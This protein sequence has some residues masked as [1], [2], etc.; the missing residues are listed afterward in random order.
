MNK[1]LSPVPE[2]SKR[3][4]A[5][6]PRQTAPRINPPPGSQGALKPSPEGKRTS[7]RTR[8]V[9][10]N[11]LITVFVI[12]VMGVFVLNRAQQSN[13]YLTEQLD[14]S[15][16]QQAEAVLQKAS[17]EQVDALD[18]FFVSLR[19]DITNLG[20]TTGDM[21]SQRSRLT[22]G[23]YWDAT[24]SLYRLSNGS[25]DNSNAD[26]VSVF[27]PAKVE[28]DETL[29]TELNT[30]VQLDFS[31]PILLK[32]N[33]DTVAVYFGGLSGETF[34]YPNVDLATLVPPDFDVTQRP[35]FVAAA[36]E[37]NP[38]KTAAWSDP[39][40]DAAANGL[41]ITTS[42][43]VYDRIGNF[44]G[45]VAMD[46]QLNR[47]TDIVSNIKL[48][49]TG[50]AFLLDKGGR[51][52]AMPEAAYQDFGITPEAFPLGN[53][54]EATA[55]PSLATSDL[56][57]VVEKMITGGSG[58][59]TI[60]INGIENFIIYSPVPEVDYN[61]AIVVPVQELVVGSTSATEQ[62]AGATRNTILFGGI[63]VAG[64]LVLALLAT[65]YISNRLTK[66]LV[67]LTTTAEEI[68]KG[69]LNAE[70]IV[71]GSDEIG[72]LATTFNNMS[73]QL[74]ELFGSL[75]ERVANRTKALA[76]STEVSR[77]LSTILDQ[78]QLLAE[79]V[80][81][82]RTAFNY[83][84]VHIY[85]LDSTGEFL[86]MAGGTGE[87]GKTMMARGHK[88]PKGRGLVGRAAKFREAVIVSNTAADPNWLPN[89]LLPETKSEIA[90]PIVAG[91]DL[92]GVL[93]VQ[94]NVAG[95]LGQQDADLLNAIANQLAVAMRNARLYQQAE[96][97]I[98][99]ARTLVEY[100]PE[101]IVIVDLETGFFTDPN[102]NAEKLY[103]LS[104]S[105][106]LK[107]GP[108]QMSPPR[109]P[110]G[111]DSTEKAMEKINEAM[112][113]GTP[114]FEW[115]HRDAAGND[116][117]CEVRLVRLPGARPRVRAS[118]TDISERKRLLEI[119]AQRA[120]QQEALNI[121]TQRI[122]S[123]STV[124]SALQVAA[125]ELGHALGMKPILVALDPAKT[126]DGHKGE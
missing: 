64:L 92:L 125:R 94:N 116:I 47:I 91:E 109:Q 48:G 8:L 29:I 96:V 68:A 77:R 22:G 103:G 120:R 3:M 83:Y 15:V 23:G 75:E 34:Y 106:L 49:E 59:E 56:W 25:W 79:V 89:P 9:S 61:L 27:I 17:V 52:I 123:A 20:S 114:I 81:Q 117:P 43:P 18:F 5:T 66:P 31:A 80:E 95:S 90:I 35:W 1:N 105:E 38:D 70:A 78:N 54:L 111:R 53:A 36:P 76:T 62:I 2:D 72:L 85:L 28:P 16:R 100:A 82:V 50:H 104:H 113:G 10:A 24:R 88:I 37:A 33:P 4:K 67:S 21:I 44:H 84:H 26:A 30:L 39:Y 46:V 51:L 121:I 126:D 60:T 13:N 71:Q 41:V 65:L 45:V 108:A 63:L 118:V 19:K 122:Q 110:D 102:P 99:E 55:T 58:L 11:M 124:E 98:E 93:D 69:N 119:T 12:I 115:T 40:L 7:L 32:S 6:F 107:V 97:S 86:V 14:T 73:S 87:A 42:Y 74:R 112:Q 101:A 57:T